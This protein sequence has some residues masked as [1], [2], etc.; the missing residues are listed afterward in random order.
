MHSKAFARLSDAD[1]WVVEQKSAKHRGGWVDPRLGEEL[2]GDRFDKWMTGAEE[3]DFPAPS[4]RAKYRG[5]WTLHVAEHLG[6]YPGAAISR[7][8]IEQQREVVKPK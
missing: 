2:L 6:G 5:I 4:T 7:S 3:A 8:A 1:R